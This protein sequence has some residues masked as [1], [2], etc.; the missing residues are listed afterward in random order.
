MAEYLWTDTEWTFKML[1]RVYQAIDTIAVEEM[2]L[3]NKYPN[4]IEIITSEQMVDAYSSVGMPIFYHHWSFGK[5]FTRNWGMYQKGMQGL[6]YE[7]VINSSPCINYLM[8]ENTMTMMALTLAHAAIGHNWFFANNAMFREWTDAESIIDYLVFAREYISKCETREGK[9]KVESF[10]DSCHSLMNYGIN[11]YKRPAKLSAEKERKR[12]E[13]REA[14]KASEVNELFDTLVAEAKVADKKKPFPL[15]PEENILYFCEKYAPDLPEWKREIIRIVRKISEYFYP[16]GQSK[17]VNEGT[18]CYCHYRIMNRLHDKGFMTDGSM[19]EF[20]ASHTNVVFQPD[21][22]DSRYNGINPYALGFA[23]MQDID[24]ICNLPTEED[25]RWFPEF[26]GCGDEMKILRDAWTN[27]RDE[28]FI[29]QFL[30]PTVIRDMGLFRITDRKTDPMYV[31]SAIHDDRG[32][33]EVRESLADTYE[34]HGSV[35]QI[36]V[37]RVDTE[38]RSLTLRFRR[39][40]DRSLNKPAIMVK[41]VQALWGYTVYLRD[42]N[43][44]LIA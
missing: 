20:M 39:F 31:V 21:F 32:Y 19:I 43:D 11:R 12:A 17:T 8:E 10:L 28:S 27:Y 35:P 30:S 40:R 13:T 38:N 5:Q 14:Y 26:A 33:Q 36:E 7:I 29:R 24:R 9:D 44:G 42:E 2:G 3:D 1:E 4:Q 41:H 22:D 6:A 18:A 34:R 15:E 25:R 16:Q 23:M 37:L